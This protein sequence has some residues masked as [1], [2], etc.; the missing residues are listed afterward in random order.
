MT[1][2]TL[3]M[4]YSVLI[5]FEILDFKHTHDHFLIE[6]VVLL[7]CLTRGDA[8]KLFTNWKTYCG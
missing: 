8:D 3:S 7:S 4:S 5:R 2:E 6:A 1:T